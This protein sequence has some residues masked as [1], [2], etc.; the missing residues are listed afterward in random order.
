MSDFHTRST[1]RL[2]HSTEL[3][4]LLTLPDT[5]L[6]NEYP[7]K[8]EGTPRYSAFAGFPPHVVNEPVG[9]DRFPLYLVGCSACGHVQLPVVVDPKRLFPPSYPYQ[10]GTSAVFREHLRG[11][12][13][14]VACHIP[15]GG[16]LVEIASNDGTF[17]EQ[18][19]G[20]GCNVLGID[21][22]ASGRMPYRREFFTAELANDPTLKGRADC[23]VALNV[24]AH[25]DDMADFALGV[26]ALL[27]PG[28]LLVVEVAYVVDMLAGDVWDTVYHEHLAFHHLTP[29][30]PFFRRHGL[31]LIDAQ[32]VDTQGGSVRLVVRNGSGKQSERLKTLL[33]EE[34][35]QTDL[36]ERVRGL[37]GSVARVRSMIRRAAEIAGGRLVVYGAPAKLCTLLHATRTA[38]VIDFVA[39]DN[40][41]KVGRYVPGTRVP[42]VSV[43]E[44]YERKPRVV[45]VASWN[46]SRDIIARH[47]ALGCEWVVPFPNEARTSL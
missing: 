24:A 20:V 39:D 21:P 22:A 23:V 25:L 8:P 16:L 5:P 36:F 35:S 41:T 45:F 44:L 38:E 37:T 42:I 11:L 19:E 6:A 30:V 40:R 31:E 7:E 10:S 28:G 1:C 12:A 33:L 32:R 14:E 13:E 27:V 26:R 4:T 18:F 9:Q 2:C 17:L 46:F 34:Q 43:E 3:E 29:L 15:L 47:S